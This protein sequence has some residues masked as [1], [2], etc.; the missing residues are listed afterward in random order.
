MTLVG[1][2]TRA[3]QRR[4]QI[5]HEDQDD[6]DRHRAAEDDGDLDLVRVLAG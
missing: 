1:S 4:A 2:A 5:E 6:Q 3:D